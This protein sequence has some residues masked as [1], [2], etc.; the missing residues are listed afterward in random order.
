MTFRRA[1]AVLLLIAAAVVPSSYAGQIDSAN[2]L[3]TGVALEVPN[4]VDT[5]ADIPAVIQT[6]FGRK[7]NE[8][9][10]ETGLT[11]VGDLTGPGLDSPVMLTTR[12]G[13][14]F[15]LPPLHEQGDYT[16]LNIRLVDSKGAFVQYATPTSTLVHVV[17][18][19]GT[20]V[21]I[22]QL[23]PDEL[24]AR[25]ITLDS[26]NY[27]VYD[28][29][30]V[31]TI[32]GQ[33][34]VVPYPIIIDRR[35]H[36]AVVPFDPP[37]FTLPSPST[38][39]P[40]P[41]FQP[42][43]F[44]NLT[45]F[46]DLSTDGMP[47]DGEQPDPDA[48]EK[49]KNHPSIPAAVIIPTGFGVLHQFFAVILK[50]SN[51]APA[52][53]EIK[54][55]AVSATITTPTGLRVVKVNPAVTIGQA[56]PIRDANGATLLVATAQ[57]SADWSL[58]AL[59]SGTHA[60]DIDVRATYKAPN[61]ADVVLHGRSTSTIV[62]SDPRFQINFVH[63]QNVRATEPY[64][65]FAFITNTSPQVQN[66]RISLESI[67]ACETGGFNFHLC[68]TD[69]GNGITELS[70]QPGQTIPVPY[71]LTPNITGHFY[72]AAGDAP[73]GISTSISLVMQVQAGD[74]PLSPA[75]LVLPYYTQFV[76]TALID[77]TMPLLGIGYSLATAPLSAQ[78]SKYPRLIENDVYQRAQDLTRAGERIFISR[79]ALATDNADEDSEPMFHLALDLL[80]NVERLDRVTGSPEMREWDQLRML[81]PDGR[82]SGAAM[83]RELERVSVGNGKSVKTF[84]DAFAAA[85]SHRTPYFL[86]LAHGPAVAGA[87]RPYAITVTGAT[88]RTSMTGVAETPDTA[89][90]TLVYGEL[91]RFNAASAS[92]T[93]ELA[94]VGRWKES[95]EL[96]ITPAAP[97]FSLD[98]IYPG[99][100]DGTSIRNS[101]NL[102]GA[103]PG[104]PVTIVID[105]GNQALNV[106]G[107]VPAPIA[108][109]VEQTPLTVTAAAQDLH[110]DAAG[111]IVTL[112]FNRPVTV[113][114]QVGLRNLF[115]LTTTIPNVTS[116][117]RKNNPANPAA[118]IV[119]PGAAQQDDG[120]MINISF[121][122][123]L[124]THANYTISVDPIADAAR[125][126]NVYTSTSIVPR[127]DNDKPG[128]IVVG[129]LLLGDGS[130]VPN[131]LVQLTEGRSLQ[132]DVTLPDGSF[133][134][135][136]VAR[137]IDAATFGNYSLA[138]IVDD[139]NARLDG[140][141]R[142][143]GEV[144]RVVLQFLGRGSAKGHVSY[145]DG[146]LIANAPVS[147]GSQIYNEFH[148]V[149]TD[150]H[151][152]Y[153]AA[154][155]PVGTLTFAVQDPK[156]NVAYATNQ[157]RTGGEVLTQNLVIQ[158]RE[159]AG[160]G[161]VR[162]TVRRSDNGLVVPGAHVG[163]YT[164]G[165]S[166]VD[167]FANV[168]GQFEFTKV[169][170][171]LVSI[172][173]ADY[174]ITQES[175]GVEFD[176]K[177]DS[178]LE[179][180]L[181]L[182]VPTPAEQTAS[183][184]IEGVVKRDDPTSP[185]D[186]SK[187]VPVPNAVIQIVNMAPVTADAQGRY[188]IPNVPVSKAGK[189]LSVFDPDT[190][191]GEI[192]YIPGTLNPGVSN[193]LPLT[194]RTT[195][196]QGFAKFRVR[197][198]A[199]TGEQVTSY[200]V[201]LP[202]YPPKL[203][204]PQPDGTYW[205][206]NIK[207][208]MSADVWAVPVARDVKYGDQTTHG[209]IRADFDGQEPLLELRLPGQGTVK[210][211]ILTLQRCPDTNPTCTPSYSPSPGAVSASYL[212][213]DETEQSLTQHERPPV[214]TDP[215]SGYSVITKV[216]IGSAN[217]QTIAHP[218]GYAS[219]DTFIAFEADVKTVELKLAALGGITG[220][221]V[222]FDGQTPL[223]GA[224]LSFAGSIVNMS[225]I[226]TKPDGSFV[227]PAA[228]G[229][230]TFRITA[231]ATVDGIF[232][233]GFVDGRTPTGGGPVNGLVIVMRKQANVS[234]HIVD[235]AGVPIPKA[236]YWARELAWPYRSWGSPDNP[237]LAGTD[238]GFFI[239]NVFTGGVRV[240]AESPVFQ[241]RR[242]DAQ[243]EIADELDHKNNVVIT[244][245][246]GAGTSSISVSVVDS[247]NAYAK[248]PN[249]EVTLLNSQGAYDF[250]S[251]DAN[252]VVVFDEL[253]AG[254]TYGVRAASKSVGRS[255]S[256]DNIALVA[257]TPASVQVALNLTGRV[258]GA[259]F[260]GDESTDVVVKGI[261][262]YL[263]SSTF[264][265]Q[266][267]TDS[268]GA[269]VFSGVPEGAFT[270]EAVDIDSARRARNATPLF[271]DKLFPDRNGIRLVLEKTA[272]VNVSVYLPDDHGNSSGIFVPLADVQMIQ[273]HN[274]ISYSREQQA[275]GAPVSFPKMR[276][277][278]DYHITVSEFGGQERKL[279]AAGL[280]PAGATQVDVPLVLAATGSIHVQ[281]TADDPLL[282]PNAFVVINGPRPTTFFTNAS[283]VADLT[284]MPLGDYSILV[285]SQNLGATASGKLL[286]RTTPL[287]L[288]VRLGS[289]AAINGYVDAEFGGVSVGTRV[290]ADVTSSAS[291]SIHLETRTD[292]AG[293]YVFNG[294]P[295]AST[296]IDLTFYG[297]DDSTI[298][299]ALRNVTIADGTTGSVLMTRVKLDATKPVIVSIFPANNANSVAPNAQVLVTFSEQLSDSSVIPGAFQLIA[300]DN[301]AT[302]STTVQQMIINGK[303]VVVITPAAPLRSNT[304][305]RFIALAGA[306]SDTTG[307]YMKAD[308]AASFTTVDYTEPR[309]TAITPSTAIPIDN[310]VTFR[311]KF[312]KPID[313][314]SYT[315]ANGGVAKLEKLAAPNGAVIDTLAVALNI[316]TVDPSLLLL[317]PTGVAIVPSSFYRITVS[318]TKDLQTPPNVQTAAQVF[319][320][321]S[322]DKIRPVVTII[323]PVAAGV[324]LVAGATYSIKVSVVDDGTTTASK[325]IQY[326]DWFTT[327]GTADT[328]V[329]RTRLG[330]DYTYLLLVPRNATT[331]TLKAS[332]TDLSFNTSDVV[333]FTWNVTPNQPPQNVTL[334]TSAANVYLNGHFDA[335]VTF[336]DE[337]TFASLN[338]A[339]TGQHADGSAYQLLDS[340]FQPSSSQHATRPDTTSP[341]SPSPVVFGVT[342]PKDLKEGTPLHVT[343][344]VT[345]SDNQASTKSSD[346]NLLVDTIP[347]VIVSLDPKPESVYKFVPGAANTFPIVVKV[348]DAESGVAKVH[349]NYDGHDFDVTT[350]SYDAVSATWTFS[351]NGLI[352]AKNADTRIHIAASA[353]DFH[354][355]TTP[356]SA[357][358]IFQ[359]VNDGTL[360][361]AQWLTPL[362]LAALPA[363]TPV[364]LTLR[365]HAIDNV[366]VEKVVF[367]SSAFATQTLTAPTSS[368]DIYEQV[369][370]FTTPDA[371]TPF[372]ITATVSDSSPDHDVVLP[373]S[374]DPVAFD[375]ANGDAMLT[376][377]ASIE[378][379]D[380]AHYTGHTIVVSGNGTDVYFKVPLTLKNLIVING[381]HVGDPD[382]I[383]LDLTIKD[384]LFVDADS[385]IDLSGKGLLGGHHVSEDASLTNSSD[386]GM[387]F[388]DTAVGHGAVDASASYGGVGGESLTGA[389]NTTYGSI[390]TPTDFGSGGA[391][392]PNGSQVGGN[393]GGAIALRGSTVT[394]DLSRFVVAGAVRA[395]GETGTVSRWG[396]GSGG[397]VLLSSRVLIT[398]PSSRI[399]ANGGDDDGADNNSTG[400]GGGRIAI[401]IS[402][403][404][405][406]ANSTAAMQVHGGRNLA[407][408]TRTT[409]DGGAGT[410]FL[411]RPGTTLGE[412]IVSSFDE[413]FPAT[414]HLTR[415][416]PIGS[417][418]GALAFDTITVSSRALAR[419]DN[420]YTVADATKVTHDAASLIV[421]PADVPTVSMTTTPAAGADVIQG[422]SITTTLNGSS[423]AGVG[424]IAFA[425][426]AGTPSPVL[427][428]YSSP[429][430]PTNATIGIAV[431]AAT[432]NATLKA[433]VT[434]RA[435]RTAET[436]VTT[437][438]VIANTAPV[439][440]TFDVTPSSLQTYAGHTVAISGAASDDLAVSTLDLSTTSG[441]TITK[442]TPV[443]TGATT[444]R[445]FSIAVPSTT[446]GGT[447]IDLKLSASDNFP[448]RAATTQTKTVT[449]LADTNPPSVTITSPAAGATFD[450]SSTGTI[451][452]RAVVTDS[453]VGVSQV[454]TTIGSGAQIA[455]VPDA[456][457]TNGWKVD[458]PVPSVDGT[459][460]VPEDIVVS[461]TDFS[462]NSGSSAPRTV[463]IHPVFDPNGAT[464]S[465]LCPS[466][467]ALFPSGYS[468]KLRVY[469]APATSDNGLTS[470]EFYVGSSTT[471]IAATL[472]GSNIYEAT[473]QLPSG[474]DGTPLP[475]RVVA[476]T[477]RNNVTDVR[478]TATIITGTTITASTT[479]LNGDT[480]YDGKTIIITGGTTTIA[481]AHTFTRLAV[482]DGAVVTHAAVDAASSQ[483]L[484][485]Q[486]TGAV[487]VS[488]GA[489]I[490][491]SGKGYQDAVGGFGRTWPNTTTGGSFQGSA[492]S[493]GGEGGHGSEAVAAAYGSI[494]DPNEPGGA[495]GHIGDYVGNQ[496]GGIVR[497][498]GAAS[499]TVDG[500]IAADGL[501]AS[502]IGSG[503]G[504]GGSIRL[505]AA[506]IG[507][508]GSVHANGASGTTANFAGGG[509][510]VALYYQNLSIPRANVAASGGDLNTNFGGGAGTIYLSQSNASGVKVADEL[511]AVNNVNKATGITPLSALSSGTVTTVSGTTVGLSGSVPEFIAGSQIDFLDATGQ[512]IGTSVI[513]SR[514]A[515]GTS[516]VL[517]S[518]PV[519]GVVAGTAYRGAWSFD[520][521]TVLGAEV[522]QAA[523]VRTAHVTT[524][525]T[526]LLRAAEV[527]GNDFKLHGRL[528]TALLD[529]ATATL[530]NG[531][532]LTHASN[533]TAVTSRLVVNA[534]TI[535]VDATSRIDASGKGY[536]DQANGYGRTWP[537]TFT[538]GAYQGSAGSHGG[539]GGHGG[540]PFATT[541]GSAF[542][543]NEPGGAGGHI[544]NFV[545]NEGGGII[546]IKA[547]SLNLEGSILVNG[548]YAG[549]SSAGSGAGGSIRIDADSLTGSGVIKANGA[550]A[551]PSNFGG[552]GGRIA[553]YATTMTLPRANV[554][555][556]GGTI[557][558][559][560]GTVLLR[561]GAQP[562]GDLII[563]NGGRATTAKTSLTSL[564]INPITS[565]NATS[566][567]NSA[568]HFDAPNSFAGINLIFGSDTSKSWPIIS[569]TATTVTVTPDAAFVPPAG[570]SFRGLYKLD[571]LK[572]RYAAVETTDL[573][574][575]TNAADVDVTATVVTGNI[576][577]PSIDASKFSFSTAGGVQLVA[578]ANAI[579]DPDAPIVVTITNGR[580]NAVSTFSIASGAPFSLYLYGK[581]G[582]PIS[583]HARDSHT[584]AMQSAEVSVGALPV[585][586]G[587]ASVTLQPSTVA[588]GAKTVATVTMNTPAPSGG[589]VI[590][591]TT[592]SATVAPVPATLTI[593]A[594]ATTANFTIT[595]TSVATQT[596][597][598]IGASY[599]GTSQSGTLTVVH[600]AVPP[601]VTITKPV[602][603]T[604]FTEGQP[605]AVEATI[606]DAEVGVKQAAAVLDGVS[607]PMTL[608]PVRANVWTATV[609]SPDVDPPSDVPKQITVIASDFENN[610]SAP[611]SVT[612]NIHP[613]IDALAPTL[614]W[615]CGNGSMYPA[616]ASAVFTVKVTPAA[617]DQ[618]NTVSITINAPGGPQTFPMTLVGG[619]YQY[620]YTVPSA[621]DGT[622]VP[623][624][625][626][627]TTFAGKTNSV[628]GTFTIIGGTAST[629]SFGADA[630]ISASDTQYENGIVI[631]SG[632]TLTIIGTHH[633]ARLAVI[634]GGTVVHPGPSGTTVS[635]LD[636]T[637]TSLYVGCNN[638]I[639]GTG[640]GYAFNTTYP[641][642][643]TPA[644]GSGGSHIGTGGL[645]DA[646]TGSTFGSVY[647]PQE[648][649]AGGESAAGL[650]G[651]GVIHIQ[652]TSVVLDGAIRADG[653]SADGQSRGGAGGSVWIRTATMGG[654]GIVSANGSH[655]NYG[656]GAGGSIAVE[657][658]SGTS[659]PWTLAASSAT[660]NNGPFV[661]GAGTIYVRGPQATYGDLTIDNAGLTGQAT[662]LPSLGKGV[663]LTGSVSATLVTDRT[664]N[665]PAYFA[666][667]WVEITSAAGV[668][669]GTWRIASV[670]PNS[671]TVT[672]APNGSETIDLAVGD[673]WQGIYRFDNLALRG[674][675]LESS[676]PVRV[677]GTETIDSGTIEHEQINVANL[678]IRAGAVLTHRAGS[679]L[680]ITTQNELRIDAG[681][682][683]DATGRGYTL[684]TT[685]PGA[686]TPANG[687]GGSHIGTGGL[688]DSPT[689][690]TFGSVYQPQE[691]GAGGE[692]GAG[693]TGG[694]VI[695]IQAASVVLDGTI[696]A[697]GVSAD[698]QSRGGA[699]GS[700][701]ISAAAMSGTGSV[702][703][704]GS[705]A[706]YGS[707]AG[708]SIA[709]EYSSGTSVPWSVT[710]RSATSNNGGFVGGA[711]TIYGRG[712]LATYGD[713][714]V[715]NGGLTGQPTNLPALGSGVALTGS[716]G[717]TLVTDRTASIPAYFAGNWIELRTA[718]GTLKGT[719]RIDSIDVAN[720]KKV[721]LK[722]NGSETIDLQAGDAWR[723]VYRFD[724]VTL[725][726]ATLSTAD[727]LDS[728]TTPQLF[729]DAKILGNN[730]GP[731]TVVA[732]KISITTSALGPAVI[733]TA[734]A[735]ADT[736][737]PITVFAQNTTT[738]QSFSAVAAADGSFSVSPRGSI[739]D[740]ISVFARDGNLFPLQS[741]PVFVGTLSSANVTPSVIQITS[742]MTN[743]G[744]FSARRLA[745]DG[746]FL[747]TLTY[748]GTFNNNK[749]LVFDVSSASPSWVQTIT[750][751]NNTRDA[752]VKNGVAYTPG[753]N[754]YAFDLSVNPA[755]RQD[756]GLSCG[757]SYSVAVDGVYAYVGGN[758][759]D[760]HIDILD[761][762]NPKVPVSLRNQGTGISGTYRQLIPYG[763]YLI[764][765]LPDGGASGADVVVIDRRDINNLVKVWTASIAGFSGFR[766]SLQGTTL[767]VNSVEGSVAVIDLSVPTLGVVKSVFQ[768]ASAAHGIA[769]VGSVAYVAADTGGVI[770]VN[771][772]D[773]ANPAAAG[774]V[775][776]S[777]QA[778]WDVVIRGQLGIIAAEDR[779][780]TFTAAL[781]PQLDASK[782]T[783]SFDGHQVTVQ[784]A[785]L[786]VLGG[787]PLTVDVRD[788]N[789][790]A[791]ANGVTVAGNGGFTATIAAASG[792]AVSVVATDG[793]GTRSAPVQ[794]G[795]VPFGSSVAIVP[796]SGAMANGDTNFR[797][798]HMA[799]EGTK[800]AVVNYP[801]GGTNTARMLVFDIAGATPVLSQTMSVPNNTRD[802]AVRNGVAYTPGGNLFAYDLSVN[803][804]TRQDGGLSC[805]DSYSVAVDGV[806]AYVGG[807]CGDG[808]ID[809]FD[810]SNP[811]VPVNLRNQGTGISGTYRQLIPYGNYLIGIT[812]DGGS[813]VDVVVLDRTNIN[814]LVK[815][816]ATA[817][818]GLVG[819][820][821][822]VSGSRLYVAGEGT[823]AT[824]AVVDLSNVVSPTFSVIPTIGGSRGVAVAGNIVAFGDGS[825]G[826]TFFDGTNP[827]APRLIGTQ[828]VGGMS[829]DVLFAGGKLYAAA[830]QGIGV[831]NGVVAP[832]VV[833]VAR[834]TVVRGTTVTVNGI[835][836][837]ITAAATPIT[838][839]AKN[840]TT[841]VTGGSSTVAADGSFSAT[842]SGTS[843]DLISIIATDGNGATAAVQVGVV[844]FGS[845]V[846]IVPISGAMAN[847][848]TN[849]RA[850]HMA[851]E[852]T[853]LAVVNYPLDGTNT[854]RLLV[855]DVAGAAP[856]LSQTVNVPNNTRDVAV[857]NGVAYTPGGNLF[858]YDLSV[859]PATRQ[860]GG[861]SCGDSYSVA[862]DGVYAYVGGNCGD[863]HIDIFDV[864]NPK[865]PVNLRNQG[866]GISGTYRQLIPYG[867]YLIGITPD[868]G[869]GVD[870]VVLDRTNINNLVRVSATAIPGIVGFRGAVSGQKLYVA[871]EGTNA[872]MAVVDLSNVVSPTFSVI[873][874]AG[875]SR[876]VAVAGNVVAFGDGS[877]GVTFFDVTNPSAP[878]LIGTQN[879]GGMSWDVLF[880]GGKLY[881][882][883]EQGI[884]VINGVVAPPVV[885]VARITVVRGTTVTVNGSAGAVTG[886][887]TP[888]T[889]QIKNETSGVTGSGVTV[890]ANGSFSAT[891]A[892]TSGDAISIVATNPAAAANTIS[893]GIVPFG[894]VVQVPTLPWANGDTNFRARHMAIEGTKLAVVNYPLDGANTN[895]L[896]VFDIAGATPVLSQTINV[897]N[898]TRDVAVRNG[899]AYTPGG[900]LFAY[901]LSV[902][903]ATRQDGGLSCGDSYSVA[904]DGAYAY[905][906][907]NC[908]DGHIDIFDVTN[909]KV[910][911]NL[912]NQGTGSGTYRQLIPYGNYLIGITPDG[913]ASGVNVVVLD[914]TNVSNLVKVSAMAI[915]G[916][917][918][919]RGAVAGQKLYVAGE[920]TNA[921]MAVVDLSNV[922]SPTFSVIPMV[923]GSRG[924]AV[925]GNL[926][927]FGDGTSGV[928]FFDVTNPSA[929]RLIGTQ[930]VGG[931]SWD[932]LFAGGKL[933]SASEQLINVVDLTGAGGFF[934][935]APTLEA[936]HVPPPPQPPSEPIAL[937]V[938][939]SRISVDERN[940][941]FVVRGTRG[942]LAGP[943]PISIEVR[944][945]T[946]GTGVPVVPVSEDGSFET[947]IGA[948]PGDHLL[949]EIISGAGEQLEIDLGPTS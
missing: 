467:G 437:F 645:W 327:D 65:A 126:G 71:K 803:P 416:T 50:V 423:I 489:S 394:G 566:V 787:L 854:N 931:M 738:G 662:N 935:I 286:S 67:P 527:R 38:S 68:R 723:G 587:V 182:H 606:I 434:D 497:I 235:G 473:V 142:T 785:P 428:D 567:T 724:H 383:K 4:S 707:G 448:S 456:S 163:V 490:D 165:Y 686:T 565:S 737:Q 496:G 421:Q 603:S 524:D 605:I 32:N 419:F 70:F 646:P 58:E 54:L 762:G 534:G 432:G 253:P 55:D 883:A 693:L 782:I 339:V 656:S 315:A 98:L 30:F 413:R 389:T 300:T 872:T 604:T 475:L 820:R 80:G 613:I 380:V 308:V 535:N 256:V 481:G 229:S 505:D 290:V 502:Q 358:V 53:S 321:S 319:E 386:R 457:V 113:A 114:D 422:A 39:G 202:G 572:A 459:Q 12:P 472:V 739:G 51:N 254:K 409:L 554:T 124:S 479:I 258:S 230:Q 602:A 484:D 162:I 589:A 559:A 252:G 810:V 392:Q 267:T 845:S 863:G 928:T 525:G 877:P 426:S 867:N 801:I 610:Q 492:G 813:G 313:M 851:I 149:V 632:G 37:P 768:A 445:A 886:A 125:P 526:G 856:V 501:Y 529:V 676:D 818:P 611:A 652:A 659:V 468:T 148:R 261:P 551:A 617:G 546:R 735:V 268:S 760:G 305:Y 654:A 669:K 638:S 375:T 522:M 193:N 293:H 337:G 690:S 516:V 855:F 599:V 291:S 582:D 336:A 786:A 161:T 627:A 205:L 345:D 896:L 169:P 74:V 69:N 156:G 608:D 740:S 221:V 145:S 779:L 800:L 155:L 742:A 726:G 616:A 675:R 401:A 521:I 89:K 441:L 57:G 75:T 709:I 908:G 36:E 288:S 462:G 25:G 873:P 117:S 922:A 461:A 240:T 718:G 282:I 454:W 344:T 715:D 277:N 136:F 280:I 130:G 60:V 577:A 827:S 680:N 97:S 283:G 843:G 190:K 626:V 166:L 464:V 170:A 210:A 228:A 301:A 366:K 171:G 687:S 310:G 115:G 870:V 703:A 173:A 849:F 881:A 378:A 513:A 879:V 262:V 805:G 817:I 615:Q 804:A 791:R 683:I 634:N 766:G 425:F 64:T 204:Q 363:K 532:F 568:A 372:T 232:R 295:V 904:V 260:D 864:T 211:R 223:A 706:N 109:I 720:P 902:T 302:V 945:A 334:T 335:S 361:V 324:S 322:I 487:Y 946:L 8:D 796:I 444:A 403:R 104:S 7:M 878:R 784:G 200:K 815:V 511:R 923:G 218:A 581:Q 790:T 207:V 304:V 619:S 49:K 226:V 576:A 264:R 6:T 22:H 402:D 799:I 838:L 893:I 792:D 158:K 547:H 630:T 764:G 665:V 594:G 439:I 848:D 822:A 836:G 561:T 134:F 537:F 794:V 717:A 753:G 830:E 574:Q 914:R 755:T 390:Q 736:D 400:A 222:N 56:V 871:G 840:D 933:Y 23:T 708:G 536:Q 926:A 814:N 486:V 911:V 46:E 658:T 776:T 598:T 238:G 183:A 629:F 885:D 471:P 741:Q 625:V 314:T 2:L 292:A 756:G 875:G 862:V 531:A 482:L 420:A 203:F 249:A 847:G 415:Y 105:R 555:A 382:R 783:M 21:T 533:T 396:A 357:D 671:K 352:V 850:R 5:G 601:T 325:D 418:N 674:V 644:N 242:G 180:T 225:D 844:P 368:G 837:A 874:T 342:A 823:N 231:E 326:V 888:I 761:I 360:P 356:V 95:I 217:I 279:T 571:S 48:F 81:H 913:G 299:A 672:L 330:P 514:G 702:S 340:A 338:L 700:V 747:V 370:N 842:V 442:Q 15:T 333:A 580:T 890:A 371:G 673:K 154:D 208:P 309:I 298:G 43:K 793:S 107:A 132:F 123:A 187:E 129:K 777:P 816:S 296:H 719:W 474:S 729:S 583:V 819:F 181:T 714:T 694:G 85:T 42:P 341:W 765:I 678:R 355:N 122:H 748:P 399:T 515:N 839:R 570:G 11:A 788:D 241:E 483:R 677:T 219:T 33:Q 458:A 102:S 771:A 895:K 265:A 236:R 19:L 592:S 894:S 701:W 553:I 73:D 270:L 250:G 692:S 332:A 884:A 116:V 921:A 912:R 797:A 41:R 493:H 685:Y 538:G 713:L 237:Q 185:N 388:G 31:F 477:I 609:P 743:D 494:V 272:T 263:S 562:Y 586:S 160:L 746:N 138:A 859:N 942:A 681:G 379:T 478:V 938:D 506:T 937:R 624:R 918:G 607:Y 192:F 269:F 588:G 406:A 276:T 711:G 167:G 868:G 407:S 655:A 828:S 159:L 491:T 832:P 186:P 618:I 257:S 451:P 106:T 152:D 620:A 907:G 446:A 463:N 201:I 770:A 860:D 59:R 530:E 940:G 245:A 941:V 349:I 84:V 861:L 317:A 447:S 88:S 767:Y 485:L 480:Q 466:A 882:A 578:A 275:A 929:P 94:I 689:G 795:V 452:I 220:R 745:F 595:T 900:N 150:A 312:N 552:G 14:K 351:A 246:E 429:I 40:P 558:G 294:L 469:A 172:L 593:A 146:T 86:A 898:N 174:S 329:A 82:K 499:I 909:P 710:A 110:L 34:V 348:K 727:R 915:P 519:V 128:G 585:D 328:A 460:T 470:V 939:R 248:V 188:V 206:E 408:E 395:D 544:G 781:P 359:S 311:L 934:A 289:R 385:S 637:A 730:Q 579:A 72:A 144:Q 87:D 92:D 367:A 350:G 763:N 635:P 44:V 697:D 191:R 120:R 550:D 778:A 306:I 596:T 45:L 731:P 597:I 569:N 573:L 52:G 194:M 16:V 920:G 540:E 808:H 509:G 99:T 157:I 520:Q 3:I 121:D 807:N 453:E 175:A 757:D 564:G 759:G 769:A 949:L 411:Q 560:P 381:G 28:Y 178:I 111:H 639:A 35:T 364:A 436:A 691:A 197:L 140:V 13:G 539:E 449:V 648:A 936:F 932:V 424:R 772:T 647:Q 653:V 917:V 679:S 101:I 465:W 215:V 119:I 103:T 347:P 948:A 233:T 829:W 826:V 66:V 303:P 660:S 369:V 663:A 47:P 623:L 903:P 541:F 498:R 259:V 168:N 631:V 213:W 897:P 398:G 83:A 353:Y 431:N 614:T 440:T 657:Y 664:A 563:D 79:H 716:G 752:V 100:T 199:A 443:V 503:A 846:A 812:P 833:D 27:D 224:S 712:P 164:Q 758:C 600:D 93:G 628:S 20:Q 244:V 523:T 507:G 906:G 476:T 780:I 930:N 905:V 307:N 695:R 744:G 821:G 374:I 90:R 331:F 528:E 699:G 924:V 754:L 852:G 1:L 18:T 373:I 189:K 866:T 151:G 876:G 316:D 247:S 865:V 216:P 806:Y 278:E 889:V 682:T 858:A 377:D 887:A 435:G 504:A 78:I 508:A 430:V 548:F 384:H 824:M 612:V 643:T 584:F 297:P 62:V 666:G 251:T 26:R 650:N 869:S 798:R 176:L 438:N 318:G 556:L 684:N 281:V 749:M 320:Y 633:F 127:I 414:N 670:T 323:S 397:S 622:V 841:N 590:A 365:V 10:P 147:I 391:G 721:T 943:R 725:Q 802:V 271:I 387:T 433:I 831:I 346:V 642:A 209:T 751:P 696:R 557:S 177:P 131:A 910:P 542:D 919:F 76:N 543:P 636:I 153:T 184:I 91:T 139:K 274:F 234:G 880:A 266:V 112:L 925:S 518:A 195:T 500:T 927:A 239:N 488:C 891:V 17:G 899:V 354:G 651:G 214:E 227:I 393:G 196:P 143:N 412:L 947:T 77:A 916:I 273:G 284:D 96:S 811:K 734:G 287:S 9:V 545:G 198:Y 61:Q 404:F 285:T 667:N 510:R 661:G 255:G 179:Q 668:P 705:H 63:P 343:V 410:L 376:G 688:W 417:T 591:L 704:N 135:E 549:Q 29:N 405:E 722:P 901:D 517:Q 212:M 450:V 825:P 834:I 427:F 133:L 24:R 698:G 809:I 789:S 733:G 853:K 728:T 141:I 362:D 773:P 137:D 944:N 495:G 835:A 118:P 774:G 649:G 775:A 732:A 621:A 640:R 641:G 857:K 892:G 750:V 108:G 575:L 512:I 243:V 455:M